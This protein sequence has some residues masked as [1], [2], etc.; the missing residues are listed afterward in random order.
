MENFYLLFEYKP[1]IS[2]TRNCPPGRWKK[3]IYSETLKQSV[4]ICQDFV[5][6]SSVDPCS[7]DFYFHNVSLMYVSV[8][9]IYHTLPTTTWSKFPCP[10]N[11]HLKSTC[12]PRPF[13]QVCLPCLIIIQSCY[14]D[15][16]INKTFVCSRPLICVSCPTTR[17]K[18]Y[19]VFI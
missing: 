10:A 5:K 3:Y 6:P 11:Q 14:C 1:F 15:Y 2:T 12:A 16:R 17:A 18:D 13:P 9:T 7:N 4:N 8:T 19:R